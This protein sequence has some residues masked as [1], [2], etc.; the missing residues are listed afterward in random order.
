[1]E[2]G[3]PTRPVRASE[4]Y[5]SLDHDRDLVRERII[6]LDRDPDLECIPECD[7]DLEYDRDKVP[8]FDQD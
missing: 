2:P 6:D 7:Q 4:L 3:S 8:E 5:K 1:M